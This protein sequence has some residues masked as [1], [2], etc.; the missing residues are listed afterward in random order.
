MSGTPTTNR[1]AITDKS[2]AMAQFT[3]YFLLVT[4]FKIKLIIL[5]LMK[6]DGVTYIGLIWLKI[7]SMLIQPKVDCQ[8]SF[9]P[10]LLPLHHPT[11]YQIAF[12]N[13]NSIRA[14]FRVRFE[15]LIA[16]KRTQLTSHMNILDVVKKFISDKMARAEIERSRQAWINSDVHKFRSPGIETLA[17]VAGEIREM[18]ERLARL[19]AR[20]K[21]KR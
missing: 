3:F 21:S 17:K 14:D 20:G 13:N 9:C 5:L 8:N 2:F 19:N 1:V 16:R 10:K 18:D 12:T 6:P 4:L 7:S 11:S 15:Q